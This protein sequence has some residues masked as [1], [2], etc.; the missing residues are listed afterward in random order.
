M[1]KNILLTFV[2]FFIITG[3]ALEATG[4]L[5]QAVESGY[6]PNEIIVKFH[7]TIADAVREHLEFDTLA[8]GLRLSTEL[9][10][11]NT[12]YQA[13]RIKPLFKNFQLN[14]QRVNNLQKKKKSLLTKPEK[15]ILK[16]LSRAPK[17]AK[18]PGLDRIYKIEFELEDG[19]SLEDVV[20][21]YNNDPGVEYAELNYIVSVCGV[22][23]DSYYPVQ[24][25]LN[26]IGQDYPISGGQYKSG[27]SVVSPRSKVSGSYNQSMLFAS[28]Y[29][30]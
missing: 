4:Q 28:R 15:R 7:A 5:V 29:S 11:L 12:R 6:E 24:W 23:D 8:H 1:E 27:K 3:F 19:Q 20:A 17:G 16:R 13:K 2:L 14:R 22:P 9:D 30:A 10:E 18:V 26:N 21:D 25:S